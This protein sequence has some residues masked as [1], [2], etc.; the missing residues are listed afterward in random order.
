ML[1]IPS[2]LNLRIPGPTP[3]PPAV[4]EALALPM[5]GHRSEAFRELHHRVVQGLK[6]MLRTE[7][8]VFVLTSSG[9]GG[10]EAAVVNTLS[11]GERVL[12]VSIGH[13]GT[14]FRAIARTYGVEIVPLDVEW[15]RA[16]E[17]EA[18]GTALDQHPDVAAVLITHNETS[19]GVT[20]PLQEIAAVV[21]AHR[22]PTGRPPLLLVDA[23]SSAG[24]LPLETDAWGLD[25]VVT[26]SQKGW[27]IPPGLAFVTMSPAAWEAHAQVKTARFYFDLSVARENLAKN[28]TPWTPAV[29]LFYG[30]AV[31][32][33]LM[34]QEGLDAIVA[35]HRR[36]GEHTR[37][38]LKAMGLKLFAD[39]R[40]ASNTVTAIH[41]PA[42]V[43]VEEMRKVLE[44]EY[45]VVLAGGQGPLRGK[46]FRI[47][48]L[49]NVYEEDIDAALEAIR[50]YLEG[51]RGE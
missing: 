22:G 44:K 36:V 5:I 25:V 3:L 15:G 32:L 9:S 24:C 49:G 8:D 11:P 29:N 37:R 30:L 18:V 40:Y 45:G 33:D 34:E 20:N 47:G 23:I 19:T 31:A 4:R 46:I 35:R 12:S 13:F 16:A 14:R 43:D 51:A 26:G 27:M 17:P 41:A 10:M 39:E 50:R 2:N 28:Q 6:A 38:R 21:K 7:N 42:G 1:N 48:H